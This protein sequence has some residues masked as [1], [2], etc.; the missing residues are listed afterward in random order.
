M[1]EGKLAPGRVAVRLRDEEPAT[2]S[3]AI[4]V[5]LEVDEEFVVGLMREC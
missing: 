1:L 2:A 4:W 5:S 3:P